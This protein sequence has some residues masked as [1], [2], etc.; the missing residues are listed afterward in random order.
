MRNNRSDKRKDGGDKAKFVGPF[1]M[2]TV[3]CA[4]IRDVLHKI[5]DNSVDIAIADPPYNLSK[6]NAWKWDGSVTLPGFGGKWSKVMEEW[7]NIPLIEY[8]QFTVQWIRELKRIVR[9]SGSLWLHG[10][11]HNSGI[12]NF[13]L[14]LLE[15]EIINEVIWY[16]RNG[17]PNLSG[18]RLTASHETIIWAHTGKR[19]TYLFNYDKIRN[20]EF[21]EDRLHTTGRQMRTVWDI[22]NNKR[23]E[24]IKFGKH[25]TQKP[26]RLIRRMLAISSKKGQTCLVPFAGSG[27][28]CVACM[29]HQLDFLAFEI[30]SRYAALANKRIEEASNSLFSLH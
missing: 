29:E 12:I 2:N 1:Q 22:P 5:P 10:T 28:E 23:R 14:Q 3:I 9:P 17:F 25:P 6:G 20:K 24:E 16:K 26:L 7:D 21:P 4:N 27:S 15:T 18:R 8:F 30:D 13:A 19:R 11:Y